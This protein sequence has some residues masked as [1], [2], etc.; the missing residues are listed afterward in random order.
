MNESGHQPHAHPPGDFGYYFHH[1]PPRTQARR[2]LV[3]VIWMNVF[4]MIAEIIGGLWTN[5]LALLSDAGHMLTHIFALVVSLVAIR[6]AEKGLTSEKTFGFYRAEPIAALINGITILLIVVV[7]AIEA[8][9][10]FIYPEP[11]HAQEMFI[12]AV[13][14]LIVNLAGALILKE[15]AKDDINIKGSFIHLLTDLISSIAIVAGGA[16]I[17]WTGWDIIDPLLS[18]V[19]CAVV[20]VWGLRLIIQS[21]HILMEGVPESVDVAELTE[22]LMGVEG[23]RAIHDVHVWEVSSGMYAMTCHVLVDDMLVSDTEPIRNAI[24]GLLSERYRIG[25]TNLQFE[26]SWLERGP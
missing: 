4:M 18:L 8:I 7:I 21:T 19:I 26:P 10:K 24:N 20:G 14:G 12:V 13:A 5:S 1:R 23:V 25:H 22:Q 11:V 17:I 9:K 16:V 3:I 15:S 6:L 2:R